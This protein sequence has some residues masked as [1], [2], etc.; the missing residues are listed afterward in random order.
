MTVLIFRTAQTEEF[1]VQ[2]A[3]GD[4]LVR[5]GVQEEWTPARAGDVLKPRD[6]MKTGPRGSATVLFQSGSGEE[7]GRIELPAEV[8]LD[9]SDLRQLSRE[10]LML[11]LTM[12]RVRSSSYQWKDN[13]IRSPNA[14]VTH[15]ARPAGESSGGQDER[16]AELQLNGTRVLFRNGFYSTCALKMLSLIRIFPSLGQS[17][18]NRLMVAESFERANLKGEALS[19]YAS[20][21]ES[22]SLTTGQMALVKDRIERLRQG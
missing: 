7:M 8:I 11:K 6:S 2:K 4:V 16:L 21:S 17:F 22:G 1:V 12:E 18:D 14:L 10:E 9:L 3:K 5:S 20:M 13:G 15:G 19:E